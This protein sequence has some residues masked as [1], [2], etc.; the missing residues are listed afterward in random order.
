MTNQP[1]TGN[2]L[3]G[4]Q[5]LIIGGTSGLGLATRS[6]SSP[7]AARYP[8]L[9]QPRPSHCRAANPGP[10]RATLPTLTVDARR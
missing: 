5:G 6:R 10:T 4:K 1:H 9:L 3:A 8:D 7:G 2:L